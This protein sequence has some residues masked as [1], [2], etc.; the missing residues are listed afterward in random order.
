MSTYTTFNGYDP[1]PTVL[2][3]LSW[4]AQLAARIYDE[5][6]DKSVKAFFGEHG[7]DTALINNLNTWYSREIL[8]GADRALM[9]ATNANVKK[10]V[11]QSFIRNIDK[12]RSVER[13]PSII[14]VI[15]DVATQ[16]AKAVGNVTEG[17]GKG[18]TAVPTVLL[19][20]AAGVGG[21]LLL[22]GKKGTKLT[23]F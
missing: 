3:G 6:G 5:T 16:A 8:P 20:I 22:A 2:T 23:P 4:Q 14:S 9:M 7:W 17:V 15:S 18:A 12:Y 11:A 19:I 10:E 21:Y 13:T 1:T